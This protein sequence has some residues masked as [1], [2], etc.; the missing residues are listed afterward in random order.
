MSAT[1][2]RQG[3]QVQVEQSDM[4]LALNMTKMAKGGFSHAA[5]EETQ[6]LIKKSH[7][8][9]E[10]EK[11]RGV[12]IL[13]HN[14]EKAAIKRHLAMVPKNQT[15]SC[16]HCQNRTAQNPLIRRRPNGNGASPP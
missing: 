13:R 2:A 4:C 6:L 14:K 11:M 12:E 1:M 16:L 10:E 7:A 3:G 9:V 15:D 5:I 8:K